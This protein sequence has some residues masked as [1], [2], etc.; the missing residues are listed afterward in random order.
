M[1]CPHTHNTGAE[2]REQRPGRHHR[3]S[4]RT[5][6]GCW[7]L[8]QQASQALVQAPVLLLSLHLH[9]GPLT[10]AF[11]QSDLQSVHLSEEGE[12]IQCVAVGT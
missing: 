12:T 7:F 11:I 6:G 1:F 3:P 9:L 10:V 2:E 8:S 5:P 4:Y